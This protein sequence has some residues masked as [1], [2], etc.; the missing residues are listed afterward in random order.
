MLPSIADP[1]GDK[2]DI[3][4]DS[5][6]RCGAD[7]AKAMALGARSYTYGLVLGGEE[8]VGHPLKALCGDLDLTLHLA[9]IPFPKFISVDVQEDSL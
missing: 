5:G 7:I 1:V 2:R 9:G 4:L 3:F 6:I 8:G